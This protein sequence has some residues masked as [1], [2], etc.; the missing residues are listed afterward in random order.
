MRPGW[1]VRW[2]PNKINTCLFWGFN[3]VIY[4]LLWRLEFAA[5]VVGTISFLF[6][7]YIILCF[8]DFPRFPQATRLD[9]IAEI[10]G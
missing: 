10:M 7:I 8:Y 6:L 1:L 5:L 4:A 9:K 3:G 2:E